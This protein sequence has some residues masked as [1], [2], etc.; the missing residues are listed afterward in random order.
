VT[1]TA[2][3]LPV[4][5]EPA[6]GGVCFRVWAPDHRR[7]EVVIEGRPPLLLGS[8]PGGYHSGHL[9]GGSVGL[10]YRLRA[11][12]AGPFADPVSRYQPE[13][14]DGPSEVVDPG[15]FRWSDAGWR[16]LPPAGQV[17]YEM[18]V[19]TFTDAGTWRAAGGE[20]PRLAELGVTALEVMPV[21]EFAGRFGWGYDGVS[22]F[23][24]YHHYGAPDDFRRFVDRAHAVG[25]GVL[26]DVV[27]NHLGPR[28]NVLP[29]LTPRYFSRRHET[30]WG[31]GLNFDEEGS[32]GVRELVL[33]NVEHWIGE[34]HLD[35][36][37]I[38][39][40][41]DVHD[42]SAEPILAEIV[43]VARAAAGGRE[44]LV[45]G[46]NEPQESRLARRREAGG[47]G[48]DMLWN[49]DFH[50]AAMVAATGRAEAYYSPYRGSV[51]ELVSALER[52]FLYQGQLYCWQGKGRGSPA[53]DLAPWQLVHF[54]QNHDQVA[55]SL[56]GRR[57]HQ[58][59]A[60][61][62][63]RALTALLLLGPQTPML[64]QG[65]ELGA[66]APFLYF[67]DH[68][69]HDDL[70][71]SVAA[72]RAEFLE[73][74]E[75][76]ARP[77][78][79]RALAPPGARETFE[80]CKLRRGREERPNPWWGL[81]RDLLALRRSDPV[82]SRPKPG[83]VDGA[84]LAPEAAVLRFFGPEEDRLLLLN[85]GADLRR[86][87]LPEPLLAPPEG[88]RWLLRWSSEAPEYGGGGTPEPFG[89][90]GIRL[91]ARSVLVL[92]PE[93]GR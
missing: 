80:R 25:I 29:E 71:R 15:A 57:G 38:D 45:V 69:G 54:L 50:H 85:L 48:L 41:Q 59:A 74:F 4:G 91:P 18:H 5:A 61:A 13:G 39:A 79:R 30:D 2:R 36:L 40:T 81:H 89:A 60:P 12:G 72:G 87:E 86:E 62:T 88:D 77:E 93:G 66:D 47:Y 26:L 35:G 14:P 76:L 58:L 24:P 19:G 42:S 84:L 17:L 70:T 90:H 49:D 92:G 52:G 78:S 3:R 9:A 8:E 75:S 55:N 22:L 21:A 23:A 53:G 10:R 16:G 56:A 67:A 43:R 64:F 51:Q 83:G 63:W 65:Q 27:Y 37:R 44:V 20:L 32:E 73:Q 28:G 46:E 34:Y 33:A 68:E 82:F 11:D 7:V 31:R 6:D 1:G